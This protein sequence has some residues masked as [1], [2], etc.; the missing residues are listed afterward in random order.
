MPARPRAY[1][2]IE[3]TLNDGRDNS[4]HHLRTITAIAIKKNDNLASRIDSVGPCATGATVTRQR[5]FYNSTPRRACPLRGT[6]RTAVIHNDY[7][8]RQFA[9]NRTDNIE[10][11]FLFVQ[12]GNDDGNK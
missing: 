10:Y 3:F 2:K 8:I 1:D 12:S 6:V 7:L 4:I 5:L 9:G 11:W